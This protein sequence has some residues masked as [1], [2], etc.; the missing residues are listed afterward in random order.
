MS[1][2]LE[3]LPEPKLQFAQF[4]E[5]ED[6]KTGLAEFGPF[7]QC[8][9]GFHPSEI[10]IGFIGTKQTVESAQ[11]WIEELAS[12]IES[13][14]KLGEA[15]TDEF[16]LGITG[17]SGIEEN[18][19]IGYSKVL[20]RDF[21]G[22]ASDT[23]FASRF[24]VNERWNSY[25]KEKT[26]DEILNLDD[27]QSS[28]TKLVDLFESYVGTI[29]SAPPAPDI[30]VVAL[31][32]VILLKAHSV[33]VSNSFHLNFRRALKA[34]AMKH[35]IPL[36]L[37][38]QSTATGSGKGSMQDKATR[39]WN[40][41]TAQYYKADGI[42]WRPVGLDKDVCFIGISFYTAEERQGDASVRASVAQVFDYL[43]QGLVVRGDDFNWNSRKYGR[44]P[45][46]ATD[47]AS[48]L[49]ERTLHEYQRRGGIPPKRVV[50]HKTSDFWDYN[51]PEYDE[52]AGFRDGIE[53]VF[54]D[55][56]T[57]FVALRQSQIRLFR[58][59]KYP[60]LRGTYFCLEKSQHFLYTVGYIPYL[61]TSPSAYVP[62]PWQISQHIGESSPKEL[63][64]EV[65]ALTKMNVNN[66]S[67]ADGTPITISFAQ[68]IGEI[69]KHVSPEQPIQPA[70]KFYM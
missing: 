40:F 43:G 61:E 22:F 28:I 39:A 50:I 2:R 47:D 6:A 48:Q 45:H 52:V 19:L 16:A 67:F 31:P 20:H 21:C 23:P 1:I 59:G 12:K 30:I 11:A 42:A 25:I 29:A 3:Y 37:I 68:S 57:D 46:L 24:V 44:T 63:L 41:A 65:L 10:K 15:R 60:P 7:A 34:R 9:D 70:Y 13:E 27:K 55:C 33:Q 69:M 17:D 38:L 56:V 36:Q 62:V 64:G 32:Q 58:E 5:H 66:C 8:L 53:K 49:I 35:N 4:F 14:K 26:I 18:T 51:H 54:K